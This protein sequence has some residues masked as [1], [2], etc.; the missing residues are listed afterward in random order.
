MNPRLLLALSLLGGCDTANVSQ[1]G[2]DAASVLTDMATID[3][4]AVPPDLIKPQD[5]AGVSDLATKPSGDLAGLPADFALAPADFALPPADFAL[6]PA[7]FALLPADQAVPPADFA[8]PPADQASPADLASSPDLA[9]RPNYLFVTSTTYKPGIFAAQQ[10]GALAYVDAQCNARAQAANL[11]GKYVAWLSTSQVAAI[12]RLIN[13]RGWMR[14]DG[15]LVFN[16]ASDIAAG[17][18]LYPPRLNEFGADVAPSDAVTGT[19]EDGTKAINNCNDYSQTNATVATGSPSAGRGDWTNAGSAS[20]ANDTFRLYCFEVDFNLA[21][22]LPSGFGRIAF[23]TKVDYN[24]TC[25]VQTG[26]ACGDSAC[27]AEASAANLPNPG[28]YKALLASPSVAAAS[29]FTMSVGALPWRRLDGVYV[30]AQATDLALGKLT[31]PID[32]SADGA[33]WGSTVVWSG[34]PNTNTVGMA[35]GTCNDWSTVS[36]AV[37]GF[38][39]VGTESHLT[40]FGSLN[41]PTPPGCSLKGRFYCLQDE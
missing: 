7:D 34:S 17:K 19:K 39:G 1:G 4:A 10:G 30:F 22:P 20:C 38:M 35:D 6:A 21:P 15:L 16:Q 33:Y 41:F 2:G 24:S 18:V 29:R 8:V 13:Y 36:T 40:F 26:L 37:H 5:M 23:L 9:T 12:S 11:P 3:Q 31:A 32:V 28:T 14:P 27:I 25:S